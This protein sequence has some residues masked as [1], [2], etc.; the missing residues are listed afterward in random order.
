MIDRTALTLGWSPPAPNPFVENLA[1]AHDEL[2][3]VCDVYIVSKNW[4][5]VFTSGGV[6]LVVTVQVIQQDRID[7]GLSTMMKDCNFLLTTVL[8][9]SFNTDT[10]TTYQHLTNLDFVRNT[11][12]CQSNFGL[13]PPTDIRYLHLQLFYRLTTEFFKGGR[14]L[15]S[16][17]DNLFALCP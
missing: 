16:S 15:G 5:V 2:T 13:L 14:L 7:L 11:T 1:D 6:V 8:C 12:S 3:S 9:N 10:M 4:N 17:N